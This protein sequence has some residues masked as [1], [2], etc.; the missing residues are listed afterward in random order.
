MSGASLWGITWQV[1]AVFSPNEQLVDVLTCTKV[2]ADAL[3][4][5]MVPSVYGMPQVLMPAVSL[6][7]GGAVCPSVATGTG[8]REK[9]AGLPGVRVTWAVVTASVLFFMV[10]RGRWV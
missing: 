3:G 1:D 6:R 10:R 5:V 2:M 4:S 9:S 7:Q 8:I